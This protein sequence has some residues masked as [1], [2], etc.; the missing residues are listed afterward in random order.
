MAVSVSWWHML[1]M[2]EVEAP[3]W[4]I[5]YCN[6]LIDLKIDKMSKLT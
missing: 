4:L 1:A 3:E 2:D 6:S 5:I